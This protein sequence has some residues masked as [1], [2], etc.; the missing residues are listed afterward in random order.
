MKYF[1]L[2]ACVAMMVCI[3]HAASPKGPCSQLVAPGT[4]KP[5][6][7]L[8]SLAGKTFDASSTNAQFSWAVCGTVPCQ[9]STIAGACQSR[10]NV[11]VVA[12]EWNPSHIVV[13]PVDPTKKGI[14]VQYTN[15]FERLV[16][17]FV[18]CDPKADVAHTPTAVFPTD[19]SAPTV[20][21]IYHK[22]GC[23]IKKKLSGGSICLII[24]T[25]VLVLY[26]ILGFVWKRFRQGKE[27]FEAVPNFLWRDLPGLVKDGIM[28]LVGK[29][30][31]T[32]G[33]ETVA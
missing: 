18:Y 14:G 3:V 31:G 28:F 23:P 27:G 19:S 21:S 33:Y 25:V 4:T 1:R 22:S 11:Q 17:V 32:N 2:L 6:Y 16:N 8:S 26:F 9:G 7:D 10:N 12:G 5:K 13:L 30:R 24:L 20:L 15:I 29:C